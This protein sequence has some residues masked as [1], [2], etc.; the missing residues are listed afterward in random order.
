MGYG[1]TS[2]NHIVLGLWKGKLENRKR[3]KKRLNL[4]IAMVVTSVTSV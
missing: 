1:T 3:T 4:S 2:W